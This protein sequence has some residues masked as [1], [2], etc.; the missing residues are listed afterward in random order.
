[1]VKGPGK[2][3]RS[4]SKQNIAEITTNEEVLIPDSPEYRTL[5]ELSPMGFIVVNMKGVITNCNPAFYEL[6][7]YSS[8]DFIGKHF[9][10]IPSIRA[11]DIPKFIKVFNS[12]LKGEIPRPFEVTYT[13]KNGSARYAEIYFNFI[14]SGHKT[15]GILVVQDDVTE[16]KKEKEELNHL[17]RKYQQLLENLQQGIWTIDENGNTTYVNQAMSE[18]LGYSPQEMQGRHLFSFMD[19]KGV[20]NASRLL[21]RRRNGIKE[22]HEFQFLRKDGTP[23]HSLLTTSPIMDDKGNYTGAIAGVQDLTERK[24]A[25]Q[26]YSTVIQTAMD[27]FLMS[28]LQGNLLDSNKAYCKL[29]GYSRE[30]LLNMNITDID[31]KETPEE[32]AQHLKQ[33]VKSGGDSFETKHR[34]KDCRIID[35]L[36]SSN[37]MDIAGGRFFAFFHDITERKKNEEELRQSRENFQALVETTSDFI[38]EIDKE[39]RYTF[40][41]PQVE[42]LWGY[43]PS[44]LLGKTPFDFL[45][46]GDKDQ[47]TKSLFTLM[48]TKAPFTNVELRSLNSNG[49]VIFMELSGVPFFNKDGEI[50]GYRGV[51]RDMSARKK[52]EEEREKYADKLQKTLEASINTIAVIAEARD[53]YTAGHQYRVATLAMAIAEELGLD[54]ASITTVRVAGWLHDIGK[55]QI[56]AEILSKPS[57][58]NDVEMAII[59]HHPQVSHDILKKM[60]LPWPVCPVVLQHHERMDGSGY[61]NGLSNDDIIMEARILAVADVVEAMASHRPYRPALGIDKALDEILKNKNVLYDSQVVDACIRLFRKKG[62]TFQNGQNSI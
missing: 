35:V 45:L 21:N 27:G 39:C 29:T 59:R 19:E 40:C 1:M 22:Q 28:D 3:H 6:T 42:R 50:C 23:L 33:I 62:F 25:E 15:T 58:L 24:L 46:P 9:S 5:F 47:V 2:L 34:T 54:E 30:E 55:I 57:K 11:K 20:K 16:K 17:A 51:S 12:L 52:A 44:D 10:S 7:G 26:Q 48:E 14:K 38:W 61:P 18:M 31:A 37:Y 36:D 4:T 60:E 32:T 49:Q 8:K 53:P 41:S 13:H 43:K 56:P